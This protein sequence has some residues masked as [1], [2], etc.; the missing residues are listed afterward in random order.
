MIKLDA[1]RRWCRALYCLIK[2]AIQAI[3]AKQS[4]L[5]K[6][7]AE[8]KNDQQDQRQRTL[9]EFDEEEPVIALVEKSVNQCCFLKFMTMVLVFQKKSQIKYFKKSFRRLPMKDWDSA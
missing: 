6:L 9:M 8:L 7:S 1:L 4:E 5:Q 3:V 2:N